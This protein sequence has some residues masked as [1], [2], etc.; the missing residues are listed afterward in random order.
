MTAAGGRG[1]EEGG[2]KC[3]ETADK[4]LLRRNLVINGYGGTSSVQ[5]MEHVQAHRVRL[6]IEGARSTLLTVG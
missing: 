3:V 2:T 1:L 6:E 4:G 5:W